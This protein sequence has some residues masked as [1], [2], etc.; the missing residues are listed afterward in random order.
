MGSSL[1][2]AF[3]MWDDLLQA[4]SK[5]SNDLLSY[6]VNALLLGVTN[7]LSITQNHQSEAHCEW[8]VHLG[9][10]AS[11]SKARQ[12]SK[13]DVRS[14]MI[15]ACIG[16]PNAWTSELGHKLLANADDEFEE[17]WRS[18]FE[19]SL[20]VGDAKPGES[21]APEVGPM[22]STSFI[23]LDAPRSEVLMGWHKAILPPSTPIGVIH[24]LA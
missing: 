6:L 5:R 18:I 9:C 11:W 15:R 13:V 3:I 8:L 17:Q 4:M 7:H 2:G 22:R 14:A 24:R 23:E 19:A 20:S 12:S 1:E 16:F 21:E 10:S